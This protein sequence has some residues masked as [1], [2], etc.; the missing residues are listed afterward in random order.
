MVVLNGHG[1]GRLSRLASVVAGMLGMS[2]A[3][4]PSD[5]FLGVPQAAPPKPAPDKRSHRSKMRAESRHM[6][7]AGAVI[8][9]DKRDP[10]YL[11]SSRTQRPDGS[12][13]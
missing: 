2:T 6:A 3:M 11:N 7:R 5:A 13:W 1:R 10:K 9:F 8:V 12:D 4:L